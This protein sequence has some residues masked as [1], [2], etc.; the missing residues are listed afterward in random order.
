MKTENGGTTYFQQY[1]INVIL[2]STNGTL[3]LRVNS[4][5]NSMSCSQSDLYPWL[6]FLSQWSLIYAC[7]MAPHLPTRHVISFKTQQGVKHF[8]IIGIPSTFY[9]R[10][11]ESSTFSLNNFN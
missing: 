10:F 9:F 6:S 4:L 1:L 7:K 5:F 2:H 3:E 8:H 11:W